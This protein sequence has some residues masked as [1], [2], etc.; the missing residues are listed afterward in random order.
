MHLP[1]YTPA[2]L[3]KFFG[4][5]P[6]L[7]S[8]T[9]SSVQSRSCDLSNL[10]EDE[11]QQIS[12]L[13]EGIPEALKEYCKK[14]NCDLETARSN[15]ESKLRAKFKELTGMSGIHYETVYHRRLKDWGQGCPQCDNLLRTAQAKLC[16]NCGWKH[17]NKY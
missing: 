10:E 11:W 4:L 2:I 17:I 3:L 8:L 14:H 6:T 1:I 16:A 7:R 15:C 12:P 5:K 9:L 13:L